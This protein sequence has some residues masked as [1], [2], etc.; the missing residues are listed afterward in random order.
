M[1]HISCRD[2]G[3]KTGVSANTVSLA[4]RNSPRISTATRRLVWSAAKDLGYT[5]DPRLAEYMRY[6]RARRESKH[7]PV[8]AL[9]N[10][11]GRPLKELASPNIKGIAAAAIAEAARHGFQL[12]EFC[13]GGNMTCQRLSRILEARGIQGI[14]VLPLPAGCTDL[15]M[16]WPSFAAV[17]TCY[18]AYALG[19]NLVTTN[20]QHDLE[21]AL[22]QL[23]SLGYRRLGFAIDHDTDERS[24]HQTLAH[25][26]WDQ[27][28]RPE[29]ERVQAL[30]VPEI[31]LAALRTWL[32]A[33]QPDAVIST[34]NHVYTLLRSLKL[35]IPANIGFASLAASAKDIPSLT[36]VDEKPDAVGVSTIDML[37][38]QLQRGEFGLP[39]T[40]RLTLVEGGWIPG[41][42]VR[43]VSRRSFED[44]R[45]L[46]AR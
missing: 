12:E 34:R 5:G 23:R 3:T 16:N 19:L 40:R 28:N 15:S 44:L 45:T 7:R 10:V 41:R 29:A 32:R 39:R 24:H 38:A 20:R 8:L 46:N 6:M 22:Q 31:D 36:G 11:H 1:P 42:T 27:S 9:V 37:V 14:V 21:L 2:I 43:K 33:E 13:V 25:F 30:S 35:A 17:S 26:L 18:S 4:L